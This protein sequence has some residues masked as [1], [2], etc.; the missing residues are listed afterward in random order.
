MGINADAAGNRV[1]KLAR[2]RSCFW[3]QH[4]RQKNNLNKGLR[5]SWKN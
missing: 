4:G 1:G 2:L 3:S 5:R